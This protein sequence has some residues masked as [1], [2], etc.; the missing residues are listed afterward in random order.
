VPAIGALLQPAGDLVLA[1]VVRVADHLEP[2]SIVVR[3]QRLHRVA[4]GVLD[5]VAGD[6]PHA[7]ATIGIGAI[8]VRRTRPR[9]RRLELLG[10]PP[11]LAE[12]LDRGQ[13]REVVEARQEIAVR[14]G[15]AG[16]QRDRRAETL[17]GA[18][19]VPQ[20]AECGSGVVLRGRGV[21]S[22][23]G[24]AV[25]ARQRLVDPPARELGE[26]EAVQD[27]VLVGGD[28]ERLLVVGD[29]LLEPALEAQPRKVVERVLRVVGGVI[30]LGRKDQQPPRHHVDR[31]HALPELP[32]IG[33]PVVPPGLA[34]PQ[35]LLQRAV[36]G[37]VE[38]ERTRLPEPEERGAAGALARPVQVDDAGE[39]PADVRGDVVVRGRELAP[40]LVDLH[41]PV[42]VDARVRGP[43]VDRVDRLDRLVRDRDHLVR[44]PDR[45]AQPA[46]VVVHEVAPAFDVLPVGR[47]RAAHDLAHPLRLLQE[48]VDDHRRH[49]GDARVPD[50]EAR[51]D[52]EQLVEEER[53]H[54]GTGR[55]LSGR[56]AG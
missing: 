49:A 40:L 2:R 54:A 53:F 23:G 15:V 32:R 52:V 30:E 31:T 35:V 27:I 43:R 19:Q 20:E 44:E 1:G 50:D 47:G 46:V 42:D 36:V 56:P 38:H 7:Q 34:D 29:R 24:R 45:K 5:E 6:V 14:G 22:H 10:E 51:V 33:R 13:S 4:H 25:E 8:R 9:E 39:R 28:P 48:I 41:E 16:V 26:A 3:E 21:R 55:S 37:L 18:F 11:V 17:R 12:N